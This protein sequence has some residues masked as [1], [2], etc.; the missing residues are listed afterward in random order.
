M[1]G[2][3][4][5]GTLAGTRV[6]RRVPLARLIALAELVL[7]VHEHTLKLEPSERRRVG[8]LVIRARG[9]S[10]NLT[11]RERAELARLVAK[12]EPRLFARAAAKKLNPIRL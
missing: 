10:R 12:A 11:S 7:L 1:P 8:Q 4:V 5:R 6:F 2:R 9:R 3:V